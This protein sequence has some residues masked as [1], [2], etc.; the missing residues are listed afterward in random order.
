MKYIQFFPFGIALGSPDS[1]PVLL[2]KDEAKIQTIAIWLTP[3]ETTMAVAGLSVSNAG[4]EPH[5]LLHRVLMELRWQEP[6]AYFTD[7]QG[8]HQYMELRFKTKEGSQVL[9]LRSDEAMSA[10]VAIKAKFYATEEFLEKSRNLHGDI[11]LLEAGI[12]AH[13]Q[14]KDR[15]HNYL[16]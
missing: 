9:K 3:I 2:M 10:C 14:L 8:H 5:T 6:E 16:M 15:L 12:K 1:R 4:T 7:V 13:P 11:S